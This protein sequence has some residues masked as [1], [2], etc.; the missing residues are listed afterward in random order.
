M[1]SDLHAQAILNSPKKKNQTQEKRKIVV[2]IHI[3]FKKKTQIYKTL[4]FFE[5]LLL[6]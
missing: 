6:L 5:C 2:A 3:Y 1:L 4:I